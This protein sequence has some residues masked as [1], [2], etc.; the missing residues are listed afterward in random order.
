[1]PPIACAPR[2]WQV[3]HEQVGVGPHERHG[4][5]HLR[6]VRQHEAVA[7]AELLDHAEDVVPAAGV[8]A[9]RVLAQLVE[10]LLHLEG[11]EDGLD[12]DGRLDRALRDAEL[13]LCQHEGVVPEPR[14]EVALELRQVEVGPRPA[15]ELLP[16]VVED[17]EPEVE[18]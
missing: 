14:L 6:A 4:H 16:R 15:L 18:E 8:Q 13:V 2:R 7:L 17:R 9:R 12:Q 3:R 1:M 5:R 11:G 10:D